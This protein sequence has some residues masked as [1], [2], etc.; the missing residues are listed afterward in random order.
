MFFNRR[1]SSSWRTLLLALAVAATTIAS[2]ESSPQTLS[3]NHHHR[4][5]SDAFVPTFS[6][7]LDDGHEMELPIRYVQLY[8]TSGDPLSDGAYDVVQGA[9]SK[10]LE[11]WWWQPAGSSSHLSTLS[12]VRSEILKDIALID[13]DNDYAMAGNSLEI[14]ITLTFREGG[15]D[16]TVGQGAS[17][18]P[19]QV[20]DSDIEYSEANTAFMPPEKDANVA[21]TK[22]LESDFS[23]PA[24]MQDYF[25]SALDQV[26]EIVNL[27]LSD[28]SSIAFLEKEQEGQN[29]TV[30]AGSEASARPPDV[31]SPVISSAGAY[32][33]VANE[34]IFSK[35]LNVALLVLLIFSLLMAM[36][37]CCWF[38]K[39]RGYCAKQ[40][41]NKDT[42]TLDDLEPEIDSESAQYYNEREDDLDM[43]ELANVT[44]EDRAAHAELDGYCMAARSNSFHNPDQ[45]Q[46]HDDIAE[47][48]AGMAPEIL[49]VSFPL[50]QER[51]SWLSLQ[52]RV[53]HKVVIS[54]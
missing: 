12:N 26:P 19:F 6:A 38:A 35:P 28:V 10:Y 29:D 13:F 42:D 41:G 2:V 37:I 25:W 16:P 14:L 39:R 45:E 43:D 36:F 32:D 21:V 44:P 52:N 15:G 24:F 8:G 1:I 51:R 4:I 50:P 40:C 53:K 34:K 47:P 5:L 11:D 49:K 20:G 31:N 17:G 18:G 30:D 22:A 3:S 7:S 9:V 23:S 48:E 54:E 46:H 27:E 33:N